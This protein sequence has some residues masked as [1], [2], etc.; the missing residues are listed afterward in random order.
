[1]ILDT[2]SVFKDTGMILRMIICI[3]TALIIQVTI[4]SLYRIVKAMI[5]IIVTLVRILY[6]QAVQMPKERPGN[7]I[8]Q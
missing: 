7:C 8:T 1:M 2:F 5:Q 4:D 6:I 3:Q